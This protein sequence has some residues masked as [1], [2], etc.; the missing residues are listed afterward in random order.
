MSFPVSK[1]SKLFPTIS[2]IKF[3]GVG[4]MFRSLNHLELRFLLS[5]KSGSIYILIHS[6][7]SESFVG[8]AIFFPPMCVSGFFIKNQVFIPVWSYIWV[9]NFIDQCVSFRKCQAVF[10]YYSSVVQCEIRDGDSSNTHFIYLIGLL[11]YC[12]CEEF[13][14]C[15]EKMSW[16]WQLIKKNI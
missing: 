14:Y 13:L 7:L 1:I 4:L 10:Y 5:I 8:D 15:C 11:Y 16:P 3:C 2:C 6:A 12:L 9:F